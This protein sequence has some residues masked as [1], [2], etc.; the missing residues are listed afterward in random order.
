MINQY[1]SNFTIRSRVQVFLLLPWLVVFCF[2]LW[3]V[4]QYSEVIKQAQQATHSIKISVQIEQLVHELQKER[5][6][7]ERFNSFVK[8]S[9]VEELYKQQ[10]ITDRQIDT[11]LTLIKSID[12]SSL[13]LNSIGNT[14]MIHQVL[15][16]TEKNVATLTKKRSMLNRQASNI[17]Q[18]AFYTS[19]IEQLIRLLSQI[20]VNLH[21]TEQNRYSLDY[22]NLLRL[23][24][25]SAQERGALSQILHS[26]STPISELQKVLL[27]GDDQNKL[28]TDLFSI[29]L[30][31]HQQW[32]KAKL[33]SPINQKVMIIRERIQEK[34]TQQEILSRL[35]HQIGYGGLIHHFKNYILRG[36][37]SYLREIEQEFNHSERLINTL[38]KF[39]YLS[40]NE[41]RLFNQLQATLSQYKK[42]VKHVHQFKIE[43]MSIEAIDE[44]VRIDD[45]DAMNAIKL[46]KNGPLDIEQGS[47]WEI[48]TQ[49]SAMF[50]VISEHISHDMSV[51]AI[52][53]EKTAI[54][55]MVVYMLIFLLLFSMTLY[56]SLAVIN[57]I[58]HKIKYIAGAIKQTKGDLKNITP[59]SID[60]ADEL[61]DVVNAFNQ[62][63]DEIKQSE[64]DLKISAAV[65]EYASEAIMI[66]DESNKIEMVNPA[67]CQISGFSCEE[68][69]GKSPHILNSGRHNQA[70]YQAMWRSLESEGTWQGE[71]WNKRKN[72]EVYP[73]FLAISVVRDIYGNPI[74]YISLFSDITKHKKHEEDMWVQSNYD[75]LTGLPNRNL[76]MERLQCKLVQNTI[77]ATENIIALLFIDLDRFKNVNDSWGHHSGDTLL[78]LTATRLLA[79]LAEDDLVAR[80]GGDEF[81]VMLNNRVDEPNIERITQKI[82]HVLS[83]PFSLSVNNEAVLSASIGIAVSPRDGLHCEL[84]V[85]NADTAMHQAKRTGRNNVQFFTSTM[86]QLV[87]ERMQTEQSLRQAI[88]HQEFVLHYQPVVSFI[89]GNIIGAEALIRWQHPEKG[90]IYPDSFIEIA[91]EAGL[92]ETIGQWVI[93]KACADLKRWHDMGLNLQVA[94]NVSS[95]QCQKTNKTSIITVIKNAL[96]LNNI[97]ANLLKV[98]ITE[99]LL[100]DNSKVML[101]TLQDIRDLGVAIHMDDFGTGYSS[102]S[103]LKHFPIDALKIDRSFIE[104]AISDKTD[105]SL[106][107]A[108]VNIGHSLALKL[109]AEGVETKAHYDYLKDLG[110]DYAQG[111]FISKPIPED[112]FL[113]FCRASKKENKIPELVLN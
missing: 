12:V 22:L 41:R 98:E 3:K 64:G 70:F 77:G 4:Y 27:L 75:A 71:I 5:G 86:N 56:L 36:D 35:V 31:H 46:L 39:K 11:F 34:L 111:Y 18:I 65:F 33:S 105:A 62:L 55:L 85:K 69:L 92:I 15:E 78:K 68:V 43:G 107:E 72:G 104:D 112:D 29:S 21:N 67:F 54:K 48:S 2:G 103:Y 44:K 59:L 63:V 106:V 49:R 19:L 66:T 42:A 38:I 14:A 99:S 53:Q 95:R 20:Q 13:S 57:N 89:N 79:C 88:K 90:L 61:S 37:V 17:E 93:E 109:V 28:I 91:E 30:S 32:L 108:V 45:S 100:M 50:R 9:S 60:G 24:E 110:C 84:L 7:T 81:V 73:E 10:H 74:Q 82:L 96:R 47:W 80:F 101:A 76:M 25:K 6:L 1:A 52:A 102:L 23:Q 113:L 97:P 16:I 8:S 26:D 40:V 58:T 83:L 51:I 94:V 87:T